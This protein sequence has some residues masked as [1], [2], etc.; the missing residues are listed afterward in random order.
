MYN[1]QSNVSHNGETL[2]RG[3]QT[4]VGFMQYTHGRITMIAKAKEKWRIFTASVA[5]F[6]LIVGGRDLCSTLSMQAL[7]QLAFIQRPIEEWVA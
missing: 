5:F 4:L 3:E 7:P 6:L 2:P 1:V